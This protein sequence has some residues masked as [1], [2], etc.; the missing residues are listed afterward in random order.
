MNKKWVLRAVIGVMLLVLLGLATCT[1]TPTKTLT[2]SS[3]PVSTHTPTATPTPTYTP[4]P[5]DTPQPTNTPTPFVG[6]DCD[7]R[8]QRIEMD[9]RYTNHVTGGYYPVGCPMYCLWVPHGSRLEVGISD[10]DIDLDIYVDRD[11]SVLEFSDHG[12]WES[13]AYGT[14]DEEVT[15]YSPDD[16]YY[17]QVCSYDIDESLETDFTLYSNFTP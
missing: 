1:F 11:L 10:F 2:P 4:L 13:N 7:S 6:G 17:I 8:A 9:M 16:R 3:T 12:Q 14:G 5:T 15:I